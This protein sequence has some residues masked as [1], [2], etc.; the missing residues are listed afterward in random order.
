M[1]GNDTYTIGISAFYHDSSAV[2]LKNGEILCAVQEERFTRIKHD[3]S[4]PHHSIKWCL[5]HTKILATQIEAVAFYDKPILKFERIIETLLHTCPKGYKNFLQSMPQWIKQK[6]FLKAHIKSLLKELNFDLDKLE[7]V[8]PEHHLSHAAS[9]F[10][11][12]PFQKAAIVTIDGVGE[13]ATAS[14]CLGEN[15][16]IQCLQQMN[17]PH[18]LGLFYSAFT[19]YCGFKVNSGEYKLMGL[20]PYADPNSC[21]VQDLIQI[22][23]TKICHIKDDGS[24]QLNMQFF[25]FLSGRYMTKDKLWLKLFGFSPRKSESPIHDDYISLAFAAQT[26]LEEAV[27]KLVQHAVKITG[28]NQV[29]LSGGVALNCVANGK[30]I[31]KKVAQEIWI[32]PASNDSGGALGAAYC[33]WHIFQQNQRKS[34][35]NDQMKNSLLGPSF[36]Q[37]Q[38][39]QEL[40]KKQAIFNEFSDHKS[41]CKTVCQLI[42]QGNIIAWFQDEMEWGPRALGNRSIL[43]DPRNQEIQKKINSSVKFR[44]DFRPFA[45]IILEDFKDQYF[46]FIPNSPYMLFTCKIKNKWLQKLPENFHNM[47]MKD[48][49]QIKKSDFPAITHIDLSSRIQT[50]SKS[51]NQKM[52]QLLDTFRKDY[53]CPMLVNTSFNVRGEPIVLS[54]KDAYTCFLRTKIDFLVLGDKLL[55]RVDQPISP[56]Q[57]RFELD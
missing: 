56:S 33:Y 8:F 18:S 3:S 38:I 2:L 1:N 22:I 5:K 20:A 42:D 48:K 46:D 43:A 4:F 19:Y 45:P 53:G 55:K 21:K 25:D 26:V 47:S 15:H 31:Q 7:I 50:V 27:L 49:L 10:Y 23:K 51:A 13:W 57:V 6:L 30:L 37:S 52:H 16:Q 9:A 39:D 24:I 41:L 14:I 29:V 44:E 11:P 40:I 12:S 36:S 54:P 28:C 35:A 32:Q 34:N 17:F